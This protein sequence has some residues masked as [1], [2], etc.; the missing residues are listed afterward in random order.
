MCLNALGGNYADAL[1]DVW[2]VL[3]LDERQR[4]L[5]VSLAET[6]SAWGMHEYAGT[7]CWWWADGEIWVVVKN[8]VKRYNRYKQQTK[9]TKQTN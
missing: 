4:L 1:A 7:R 2:P 6:P 8:I 9:Q 5:A 3:T